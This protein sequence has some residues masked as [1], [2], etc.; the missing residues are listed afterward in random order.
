MVESC[1]KQVTGES[2]FEV[3]HR[4]LNKMELLNVDG[5]VKFRI[6]LLNADGSSVDIG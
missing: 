3:Y 5:G 1:Y 2:L 6:L 4:F